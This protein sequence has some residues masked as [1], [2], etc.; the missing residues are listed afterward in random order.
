MADPIGRVFLRLIFMVVIPLV[1]SPLAFSAAGI[2]D[3][4]R[5]GGL[6]LK[7]LGFTVL[8]STIAVLLGLLLV[9]WIGPGRRLP[10]EQQDALRAVLL[11]WRRGNRQRQAGEAAWRC[12]A[13]HHSRKPAPGNGRVDGRQL[14]G[15]PDAG[16]DV[17][18][19]VAGDYDQLVPDACQALVACL[20]GVN[21]VS[22]VIIGFAMP[23]RPA[24]AA[25][26]S[27]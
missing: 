2:G 4:R 15:Q 1:F 10:P 23:G 13:G 20:E 22:M 19:H 9:N 24:W 25:W 6:G 21:A 14:E 5:L 8:L 16:R 27:P 3:M 17:L 26:C 7:T 11:S 18:R 12:A